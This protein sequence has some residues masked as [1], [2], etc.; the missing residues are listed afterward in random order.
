MTLLITGVLLWTVIHLIPS[1]VRPIRQGLVDKMGEKPYRGLFALLIF[2]SLTLIILGWRSTPEVAVYATP[3]WSKTG[4]F[5]L[6]IVSFVLIGAAQYQSGIKRF[7]RHPMLAGVFIWSLSHLLTNGTTRALILF[8]GLG[9]WAL[10]E[11]LLINAREGD[12][13]KPAARGLGGELRGVFIS[14]AFFAIALFL[15]P[16]FAGVTPFPR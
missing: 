14:A 13:V 4:G 3:A 5:I 6:M 1:A 2:G 15:H 9:I 16:Y 10:I 8:G 12:Y 11:I 7:V